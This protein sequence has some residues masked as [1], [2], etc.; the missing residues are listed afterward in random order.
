MRLIGI[1]AQSPA[2]RAYPGLPEGFSA[3][4]VLGR[5]PFGLRVRWQINP[6]T[7]EK[8]D[9]SYQHSLR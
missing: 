6:S 5:L 4:L 8:F 1:A 2:A 7:A 3:E 9:A